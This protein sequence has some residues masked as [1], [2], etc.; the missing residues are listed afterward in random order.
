KRAALIGPEREGL[1][2]V[3]FAVVKHRAVGTAAVI[4]LRCDC[5]RRRCRGEHV[6]DEALV[7]AAD[8]MVH[9][10]A[11]TRAPVPIEYVF[12]VRVPVPLD[13]MPEPIDGDAKP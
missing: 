9:R 1:V 4:D 3:S 5:V 7:P 2:A 11:V 13:V 12:A 10:P 6:S 8:G